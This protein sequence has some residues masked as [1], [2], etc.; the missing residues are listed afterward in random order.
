MSKVYLGVGHGGKDSGAVG[1]L[2]EKNVNLVMALACRD[3]L[4]FNGIEVKMSRITDVDGGLPKKIEEINKYKPD[5]ALDIHNNSGGGN[6]FEIYH[7]SKG[8][9]GETLAK[10]IESEVIKIGQNSRGCKTKIE[11]GADYF[12]FIRET[13]CPAVICEGIF[14][15][16]IEDIQIA[17]SEE[18]QKKFG[19]AYA[20]GILHSLNITPK[21]I[22]EGKKFYV[23]VGVYSVKE[24][25]DE[26]LNKVKS[27]GFTDA[28]IKTM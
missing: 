12:G 24:N 16:N 10:N 8:G 9:K 25:A 20:R 23:Q 7:Y 22:N 1:Y 17:N 13:I 21:E 11:N 3:F 27:A 28:F 2:V 5:Y 4:E 15:D 14:V 26:Q 18:K 19:Y 6:G